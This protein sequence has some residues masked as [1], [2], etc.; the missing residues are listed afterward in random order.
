MRKR[1]LRLHRIPPA[2]ASSFLQSVESSCA[3]HRASNAKLMVNALER[4]EASG[5]LRNLNLG[6]TDVECLI[7]ALYMFPLLASLNLANNC[8]TNEGAKTILRHLRW[9]LQ[10]ARHILDGYV[11]Y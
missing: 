7:D 9:Q 4:V 8:V 2:A 1:K 3:A 5:H 11:Y 6:D 10:V